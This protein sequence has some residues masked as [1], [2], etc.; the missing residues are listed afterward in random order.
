MK[1]E[2]WMSNRDLKRQPKSGV[3][4]CDTCDANHVGAYQ[5][6]SVCRKRSGRKRNKR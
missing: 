6:C 4:Y 1:R 5:K 3:F 2:I